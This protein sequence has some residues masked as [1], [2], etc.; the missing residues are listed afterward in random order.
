[1]AH[2]TQTA[3][4]GAVHRGGRIGALIDPRALGPIGVQPAQTI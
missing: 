4:A 1:M 3:R 2:T